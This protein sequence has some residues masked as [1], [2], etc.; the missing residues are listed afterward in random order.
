LHGYLQEGAVRKTLRLG[1]KST[2][3]FDFFM[4]HNT[5]PHCLGLLHIVFFNAYLAPSVIKFDFGQT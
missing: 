4:D 1:L 2:I 5:L 3:G